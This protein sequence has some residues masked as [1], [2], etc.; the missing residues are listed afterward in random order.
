[1]KKHVIGVDIGT[2]STKAIL[3]DED[4]RLI[5]QSSHAYQVDSP[6][7]LWAEQWPEVWMGALQI[8]IRSVLRGAAV[9]SGSIKAL[10]IDSLYG[11]SGIP[12]DAERTPLHPCLIWM[13][14]RA[15][16]EVDWVRKH[17]DL[18]RLYDI[19]GNGVDSYYGYTKMLWLREKQPDIW[20]RTREFLPPS[21]YV[22]AELTGEVAV[23]HSSAGNIGG[24]YDITRRTWSDEA[25]AMLGIPRSMMPD[26]LV[27]SSGV[28]GGLLAVKAR[29][30]GLPT[31]L[32]VVGGG[33]DAAV[34]TFAAG[35]SREGNHVL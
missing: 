23:D 15:Q 12:V 28:V 25:L 7:P 29:E 21:S 8:R 6:H 31:G 26:R 27:E 11:G 10:C 32:P 5:A 14:R 30:L 17:V 1:M 24:V 19:T 34:A 22:N 33:V 9:D 35:A 4:G 20:K 3:V 18:D 2:Q 16:D 13:D